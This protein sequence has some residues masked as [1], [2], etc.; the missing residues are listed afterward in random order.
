MCALP[1]RL[2]IESLR[3]AEGVDQH[4]DG[5]DISLPTTVGG[6]TTDIV[7]ESLVDQNRRYPVERALNIFNCM[8]KLTACLVP[9]V[10]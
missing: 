6:R 10:A 4:A 7:A 9:T 3:P 8:S 2:T 1:Q 5:L